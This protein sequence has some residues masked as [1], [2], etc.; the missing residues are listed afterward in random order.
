MGCG[1]CICPSNQCA[2]RLS[3][4]CQRRRGMKHSYL[5]PA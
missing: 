5:F 4:F 1:Y 3:D 2:V